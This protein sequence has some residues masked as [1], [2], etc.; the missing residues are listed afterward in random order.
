[1]ECLHGNWT[2]SGTRSPRFEDLGEKKGVGT[3]IAKSE[4]PNSNPHPKNS[5]FFFKIKTRTRA[6]LLKKLNI[7]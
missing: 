1:V 7:Y 4:E 2:Q 6:S 3:R 5:N